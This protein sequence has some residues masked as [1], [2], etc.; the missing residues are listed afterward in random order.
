MYK[1]FFY[2]IWV[3]KIFLKLHLIHQSYLN[4]QTLGFIV[5]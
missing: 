4:I 3:F 2:N 1:Y 5:K